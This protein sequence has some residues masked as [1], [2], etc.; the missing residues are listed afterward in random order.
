MFIRSWVMIVLAAL[1]NGACLAQ[2]VDPKLDLFASDGLGFLTSSESAAVTHQA[3]SGIHSATKIQPFREAHDLRG[4][5][6]IFNTSAILAN[7][8]LADEEQENLNARIN[9]WLAK[10][11]RVKVAP[12]EEAASGFYS[13]I[14]IRRYEDGSAVLEIL[15]GVGDW[16]EI[17][18]LQAEGPVTAL[19]KS[20]VWVGVSRRRLDW[21]S[22]S[23]EGLL[24]F[25]KLEP[26][27]LAL[28]RDGI[29]SILLSF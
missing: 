26:D 2:P 28:Y 25:E 27:I 7:F 20:T 13:A 14:S 11:A 4:Y 16:P 22:I 17:L 29:D 15:V 23:N 24:S 9:D 10:S 12:G 6:T 5:K 21:N 8:A 18:R 3:N 1:I 19:A